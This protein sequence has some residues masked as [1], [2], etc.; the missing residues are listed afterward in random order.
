MEIGIFGWFSIIICVMFVCFAM[1]EIFANNKASEIKGCDM[2]CSPNIW[3]Q[4]KNC[5]LTCVE[6]L[7]TSEIK[8][9]DD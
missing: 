8:E 9:G 4:D 5:F 1:T 7:G 2:A 6:L 3:N